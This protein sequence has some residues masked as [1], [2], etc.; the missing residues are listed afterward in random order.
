MYNNLYINIQNKLN[1]IKNNKK[2]IN[3]QNNNF[4]NNNNKNL[5]N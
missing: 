2:L 3:N 4:N 1:C 5:Y